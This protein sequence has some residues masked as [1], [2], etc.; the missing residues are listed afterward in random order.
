MR[1]KLYASIIALALFSI[2]NDGYSQCSDDPCTPTP[3]TVTA[4]G[5][6]VPVTCNNLG[7]TP[8]GVATFPCSGVNNNDVWYSFVV[9][10]GVTTLLGT[11]T[12]GAPPANMDFPI[13][14]FYRGTCSALT[15][16]ACN[17]GFPPASIG[18]AMYTG[19]IPGET[20]L[21][22]IKPLG[23][24]SDGNFTMCIYNPCPSGPPANDDPCGATVIPMTANCA[25][26]TG[27]SNF[28]AT[29]T[30]DY[31]SAA[32]ATS[33]GTGGK[34]I[35]VPSTLGLFVGMPVSVIGGTGVF[36]AG[37]TVVSILNATQFTV[38]L[39]PTTA[40]SGGATI[41]FGQ[42]PPPPGCASF[43]G[44]DIWL[45][46]TVPA[47]GHLEVNFQQQTLFDPGVAVYTGTCGN[48]TLQACNDDGGFNLQP[49]IFLTTLPPGA[50]VWIRVW[51]FG[52]GNFGTMGICLTDPCPSGA[53]LNDEPCGATNIAMSPNPCTN[54]TNI[55]LACSGPTLAL[56]NPTCGFFNGAGDVWISTTVG[57]NGHVGASFQSG[58]VF[59][60]AAALYTGP[61]NGLT[62]VACDDNSG[63][64]AMPSLYSNSLV[65][66]STVYIR[67]WSTFGAQTGNFDVCLSDP[68]PGGTVLPPI[69]DD[70]PC[71]LPAGPTGYIPF[72]SGPCNTYTTYSSLCANSGLSNSPLPL[73]TQ[74][75]VGCSGP[76]YPPAAFTTANWDVW[77]A[78]IVPS[79]PPTGFIDINTQA[80]TV[81]DLD[82]AIYRINGGYANNCNNP[83]AY[84]MLMCDDLGGAVFMPY[85]HLPYGGANPVQPGDTILIRMWD[86][87][88]SPQGNW[89]MCINNPCPG[90]TVPPPAYDEPPC[91]PTDSVVS[92]TGGPCSA[93]QAGNNICASLTTNPAS[94]GCAFPN[95]G[96]DV[97][98]VVQM[99]VGGSGQLDF[100][101]TAGGGLNDPAMAIYSGTP[102][103]C[104]GGGLTMLACDDDGGAG[105][106]PYISLTNPVAPGQYLYIRIWGF[107][108]GSGSFGG[109][110]VNDPCPA[111]PANDLRC[112]ATPL[113]VGTTCNFFTGSIVCAGTDNF[114]IAAPG[115]GNYNGRDVWYSFIAPTSG[116]VVI[117]S[118]EGTLD[119]IDMAVY[120]SLT[121][122]NC[123]SGFSVFAGGCD[124][125]TGV[126]NMPF[127]SLTGLTP[128]R[129]YWLRVWENGGN[130]DGDFDLCIFNPCPGGPP[131]NDAVCNATLLSL[132]NTT[133]GYNNCASTDAGVTA[134]SCWLNNAPYNTPSF[135]NTVWFKVSGDTIYTIVVNPGTLA[136]PQVSIYKPSIG[137]TCTSIGAPM[138]IA[139]V[140]VCDYSN[141]AGCKPTPYSSVISVDGGIISNTLPTFQ[142][143][144]TLYI[145]VEGVDGFT[146]TFDI[147]AYNSAISN[148]P[149]LAVQDC[150]RA[151]PVCGN[152]TVVANP[153][154][155][156]SGNIC[157]LTSQF[158][159]N[160]Y[161]STAGATSSG[162]TITV[163][164]TLGLSVGML[165]SVSAGTGAFAGNTRVASITNATT[166]VASSAPTTALS[167]GASVVTG[168]IF[169]TF[170]AG[171]ASSAGTTV[172]IATTVG[173]YPGMYVSVV[174]GAGVFALNTTVASITN[175][176]QFVVSTAPTTGLAGATV[177][178]SRYAIDT[179]FP[180]VNS[181]WYFFST[182]GS[183]G[184]LLFDIVG[185]STTNY[186][187]ILWDITGSGVSG[188]NT[189]SDLTTCNLITNIG[190]TGGGMGRPVR[191]NIFNSNLPTGL[192]PTYTTANSYSAPITVPA[193]VQTYM[194]C[195][196]NNEGNNSGF[197]MDFLT[198][199]INYTAS[200]VVWNDGS[201]STNWFDPG[202]WGSCIAPNCGV[203]AAVVPAPDQ[204]V[205]AANATVNNLTISA[206]SSL[207]LAPGVTLSI[208]GN[209]TNNGTFTAAPSS[210]VKFVG[211]TATGATGQVISGNFIG[212][213]KL[214]NVTIDKPVIYTG[215]T[216][217]PSAATVINVSSTAG[218][219]IG[220]AVFL[221][222]GIG[223]FRMG[224]TITSIPGIYTSAAGATSANYATYTSAAGATG[225]STTITVG[226]TTGLFQGMVV[227]VTAGIGAF[228]PR[229]YITNVIN[230]TQFSV[231]TAPTTALSGGATVVTAT[232]CLITVTATAGLL[233][234]QLITVSAGT[235]SFPATTTV[236]SVINATT[237]GTSS[238]PTV[239]LSGGAV[240]S[241]APVIGV[242]TAPAVTLGTGAQIKAAAGVVTL[243]T[244]ADIGG[245]LNMATNTSHLN[246]FGRYIKL[247]GNFSNAAGNATFNSTGSNLEFSGAGVQSFVNNASI[248][249]YDNATGHFQL[250]NVII[251]QNDPFNDYVE[252]NGSLGLDNNMRVAGVLTLTSGR[253]FTNQ[254]EVYNKNPFPSAVVTNAA[255]AST[256]TGT[257]NPICNYSYIEGT[258]TRNVRRTG[259]NEVYTFAVG[260]G[261]YAEFA[262][263][264]RINSAGGAAT[265]TLR[266]RA[267]FNSWPD[268]SNPDPG[269]SIADCPLGTGY[270]NWTTKPTYDHGYWTIDSLP[271]IGTAGLIGTYDLNLKPNDG[272]VGNADPSSVFWSIMKRTPSGSGVW[273]VDGTCLN[274]AP[275]AQFDVYRNAMNK[276]SDFAVTQSGSTLPIELLY[277]NAEQTDQGVL[278]SWVTATEIDNDYFVV[279]RS[280]DGKE[281]VALGTIDGAGNSSTTLHYKFLDKTV[282]Y[283]LAYYRLKQ[284]DF[285][286]KTTYYNDRVVAVDCKTRNPIS[287]RPNPAQ[288]EIFSEFKMSSDAKVKLEVV[289][290]MGQVVQSELHTVTQG[291][292][293]LKTEI[294]KLAPGVYYMK[295]TKEGFEEASF[296]EKFM[297]Y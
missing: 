14:Y 56:P 15:H 256:T 122:G 230:G 267:V 118:R 233:P 101:F 133:N 115:C 178:A 170:S 276:F 251:N 156:N 221:T 18:S 258:H 237:F 187:F 75:P 296:V 158:F 259:T 1:I 176:T 97:W 23:G 72:N 273:T 225:S 21:V 128:G 89:G 294:S 166:F 4:N 87:F 81:Q 254:W 285:D 193:S 148:L 257:I 38:S 236:T 287:L 199:P 11:V 252:L 121:P 105:L 5:P 46:T 209:F 168:Q 144:D 150:R 194:L 50:Q 203:H 84:Q 160:A 200:S 100:N 275:N 134:A 131:S 162:T 174:A 123:N 63:L 116:A 228:A 147:A 234:G 20:I 129:M 130:Q 110:C 191:T 260:L 261:G 138:K 39:S 286:G 135:M 292:N 54:W 264:K 262:H 213:N 188:Q 51:D 231:S 270:A 22:R 108:G 214:P 210:T 42:G 247:D 67:V 114:G 229:T 40:L 90:G 224:T 186:D 95:G 195:V 58:S 212:A 68:C 274:G 60:L 34:T 243:S 190:T 226:T 196:I 284:V 140:D 66:G 242:S 59:D 175:G 74:N 197:T 280:Y 222:A 244:N 30:G 111:Q 265:D 85:L 171:G 137:Q 25:A 112:N 77:S 269:P 204:P 102:A 215:T 181:A 45:T 6:C 235:G 289:D 142:A 17:T 180:E 70:P 206:G 293:V 167:G 149:P 266:L 41:V 245:N 7:A 282:C 106:L 281:F 211:S 141:F 163:N 79:A 24:T 127:L 91:V 37:T 246:A 207:S 297:K 29:A 103:N 155:T 80:G 120:T 268:P 278:C 202:N 169:P 239:A 198:S 62:E 47:N 16:L 189:A 61:C 83:A 93:Y 76:F 177:M 28:C 99:P 283:G 217:A 216:T 88:G 78:F 159:Y 94:A 8:S 240:V 33:G 109:F 32:G 126:G 248:A 3:I 92:V 86:Y 218:L 49:Y 55:S 10:P 183:A 288:S 161:A 13:I 48:L 184:T 26:Y 53:A 35:T 263:V 238:N 151:V 173:L 295:I 19:F 291:D 146:G 2:S 232:G 223:A 152:P 182:T 96:N 272:V 73:G 290:I 98:Y 279:E 44:A 241:G 179:R 227:S 69:F 249:W 57:A 82:I 9:P 143:T 31:T 185:N 165:L 125:N 208:C 145:A 139:G 117:D 271:R 52:G 250:N 201:A 192:G 153:G 172:T 219:S 157:D 253:I 205:I 220:N 43:Q 164:S 113:T 104:G 119:N 107:A 64:G 124:D 71:P 12:G 65:P 255:C 277:F 27:I 136:R 132:N 154:Y 36:A